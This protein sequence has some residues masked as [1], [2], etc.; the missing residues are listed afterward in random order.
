MSS[1]VEFAQLLLSNPIIAPRLSVAPSGNVLLDKANTP[2]LFKAFAKR[3]PSA[4]SPLSYVEVTDPAFEAAVV[5]E[6]VR[7]L[8]EKNAHVDL[9]GNCAGA[10]EGVPLLDFKV[11]TNIASVKDSYYS[12]PGRAPKPFDKTLLPEIIPDKDVRAAWSNTNR[13]IASVTYDFNR[14]HGLF[15]DQYGDPVFNTRVDPPWYKGGEELPHVEVCPEPIEQL[16]E[17]L[18]PDT[19]DI[20]RV[21]QWVAEMVHRRPRIAL[22]LMGPQGIG[23]TRFMRDFLGVLVGDENC[24]FAPPGTKSAFR[25]DVFAHRLYIRDEVVLTRDLIEDLKEGVELRGSFQKKQ[26]STKLASE[27]HTCFIVANNHPHRSEFKLRERKL[28][29]PRMT[30]G[31]MGRKLNADITAFKSDIG[32]QREFAG[33]LKWFLASRTPEQLLESIDSYQT[34]FFHLLAASTMDAWERKLVSLCREESFFASGKLTNK[35]D[36]VPKAETIRAFIS[37]YHLAFG[38]DLAEVVENSPDHDILISKIFDPQNKRK[39][40][41]RVKSKCATADKALID[42]ISKI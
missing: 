3:C 15:I 31:S 36:A 42:E 18:F 5:A 38:V 13:L 24:H 29:V 35:K 10:F 4:L 17:H 16:F 27:R 28:L 40:V 25:D 34:K 39:R 1:P 32:L 14:P 8:N 30:S 41:D 11:I 6:I 9:T 12:L 33:Y 26:V 22:V 21:M 2:S 19:E 7:D 20:P 23:K 37:D